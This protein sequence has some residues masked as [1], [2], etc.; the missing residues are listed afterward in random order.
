MFLTMSA[1]PATGYVSACQIARRVTESWG[2]QN[3]YCVACAA[4]RLV[5]RP[6]NTPATDFSCPECSA[7]YQLK[8]GQRWSER[9]IPDAG[10][11][12]MIKAIRNDETPNLL[13]MQ[14][15]TTS[16]IHHLLLIPSFFFNISAI[17]KRRP[18]APTARRAGWVGCNISLIAIP[19]DGKL[20]LVSAGEIQPP[21][22][23]RRRYANLRQLQEL[24]P[25]VREWALDVLRIVRQLGLVTFTIKEVY[26]HEEELSRLHPNNRHIR[27]K[28]RQQLQVLRD[29]RLLAFE[30]KGAYRLLV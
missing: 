14:Y 12:A 23:V 18:L 10:Y 27:A 4:D 11:D 16:S 26:H 30:G 25:D 19:S 15:T 20:R 17:E 3:L 21:T 29:M 28:I 13:V 7:R 1:S 9:K 8:A 6:C 22:E 5:A 2:L 24:P